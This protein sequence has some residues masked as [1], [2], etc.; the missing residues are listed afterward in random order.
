MINNILGTESEYR[1]G[2][3]GEINK[4]NY[5]REKQHRV[6]LEERGQRKRQPLH[7]ACEQEIKGFQWS[8]R[9]LALFLCLL[10]DPFQFI[11]TSIQQYRPIATL[12]LSTLK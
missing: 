1:R 7:T 2:C 4:M 12:Y 11:S 5:V 9:P 10:V 6:R 8:A 3:V